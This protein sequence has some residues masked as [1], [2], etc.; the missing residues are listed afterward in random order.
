MLHRKVLLLSIA[1]VYY[2]LSAYAL[3][4]FN[5]G[6]LITTLVLFGLPAYLFA[7]FSAVP[8]PVIVA[9]VTL[10]G[11]IAAL[12]EGVA[13][14]YGMWYSLGV[15]ELRLFGL[16]PIEVLFSTIVQTLFLALLYELVFD[17]GVYTTSSARVRFTAFGIFSISVLALIALHHY[18]FKFIFLS[19]SYVWVLG[20]IVA[21]TVAALAVHKALSL[22]FFD[23]L[24]GFTLI[25]CIPL[26]INLVLS[27][28]NTHKVFA[29]VNDYLYSFYLFGDVI[30]LE[31]V[32]LMLALPLFVATFY[33]MYLDDGSLKGSKN[34]IA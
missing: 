19:H 21:A 18:L 31:E 2:A 28:T 34:S 27:V 20:I 15:D 26:L 24:A 16:I 17:D 23:R 6:S 29:H 3:Y 9:V 30:P 14:I 33:E 12:L 22:R 32:L 25:A 13:H 11:G 1:G 7:R 5:A 10:G 8:F 4:A